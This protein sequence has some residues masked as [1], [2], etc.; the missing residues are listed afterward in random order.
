MAVQPHAWQGTS[1]SSF[2][3]AEHYSAYMPNKVGVRGTSLGVSRQGGCVLFHGQ[4]Q[5]SV[6]S[7]TPHTA[8]P[9]YSVS[10]R[11]QKSMCF[12]STLWM[13]LQ[14]IQTTVWFE[15]C[16]WC[17]F[18][19]PKYWA[20]FIYCKSF[21]VISASALICPTTSVSAEGCKDKNVWTQWLQLQMSLWCRSRLLSS[22]SVSIWWF[23]LMWCFLSLHSWFF[24]LITIFIYI[25]VI[26]TTDVYV[27]YFVQ[28]YF[29]PCF[30]VLL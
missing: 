8:C 7:A 11:C 4:W 22:E 12:A 25:F 21:L 27:L 3:P 5:G 20:L 17:S 18:P 10:G 30:F 28:I 16:C 19:N 15:I 26:T 29:S 23:G 9:C 14:L 6:S 2:V 24:D 13:I 1:W